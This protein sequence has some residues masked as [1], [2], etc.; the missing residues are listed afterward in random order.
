MCVGFGFIV[1]FLGCLV[2]LLPALA[3]VSG[4]ICSFDF[5]DLLVVCLGELG[6]VGHW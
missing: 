4:L 5:F 2:R 1:V 3:Y 6:V